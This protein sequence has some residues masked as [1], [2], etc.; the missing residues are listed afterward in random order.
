MDRPTMRAVVHTGAPGVAGF[1]TAVL[2]RPEPG[3]GQVLVRIR[4]AALNRHDLFVAAGRDG[5]EPPLVV[6][7]DGAGE[8]VALGPG[9]SGAA[10]GDEVVIDPT[11][12]WPAADDVPGVPRLLGGPPDGTLAEYVAVPAANAHPRPEGWTG[13]RRRPCRSWRSRRSAPCSP[14]AGCVPDSTYS[15]RPCPAGWARCAC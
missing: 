11:L 14:G 2:P 13:R 12:G 5:T 9:A 4:C 8:V 15:S 3:P 7:S 10:V 1:R 6:G